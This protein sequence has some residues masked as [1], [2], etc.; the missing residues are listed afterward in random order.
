MKK[1]PN[2]KSGSKSKSK[3]ESKYTYEVIELPSTN[4]EMEKYL[5]LHRHEI[6]SRVLNNI[7]YAI[8]MRLPAVEVFTFKNSNF[9]V[10]MNRKDFKENI[11]NIIEFSL[12]NQDYEVCNQAKKVM[13]RL[14][15]M[16]IVF[17]YP[18]IKK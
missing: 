14:D 17:K 4:A 10:M 13:Q 6:N 11:E 5:D 12:K 15:R 7:E 3:S 16:S 18:K 9:V 8:K 2:R 1:N